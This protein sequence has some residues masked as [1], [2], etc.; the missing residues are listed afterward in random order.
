MNQATA[1]P[2]P[3]IGKATSSLTEKRILWAMLLIA[4]VLRLAYGLS[5]PP[6]VPTGGD[7]QFYLRHGYALVS[8]QPVEGVALHLLAQPPV[9]FLVNGLPQVIFAPAAAIVAVRVLQAVM[10][11][12]TAYFA[13]RMARR[14]A[15]K[16]A[17]WIAVAFVAINPI[18]ILENG[19]I[20]T[21]S[22]YV[23]LLSAAFAMY[24]DNLTPPLEKRWRWVLAGALLGLATLTRA[25]LLAFPLGLAIHLLIVY[26][27]RAWSKIAT[28]LIVYALVVSTWTVYNLVRWQRFVI[29]GEGLP[30][31][32]YV[33]AAGWA[34]PEVVDQGLNAVL[35]EEAPDDSG[36]RQG[37]YLE[38]AG[39]QIGADVPGYLRR[40]VGELVGAYLQPHGTTLFS[41]ESLRDL[42]VNWL[43]DDRS[44][45]G[46]GRVIGGEQFFPKLLLYVFHYLA[47]IFGV[48][49]AWR[50]RR[51]WRP[52]LPLLGFIAYVTLVHFFLLALPR[53]IFPT[54]LCWIVLASSQF[55]VDSKQLVQRP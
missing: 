1:Q 47:L 6:S 27:G 51:Q 45:A 39:M 32:L 48:I 28:L 33:G 37:A 16:R 10:G 2:I 21:E 35:G 49:G 41:G 34:D 40:R 18:F 29:A 55:K 22:T 23:F 36:E 14:I 17:G 43:R 19:Q 38:A 8:G 30:S 54:M 12:L 15:G 20:L 46:I 13:Y 11:T 50:S 3:T 4:L 52:T 44:L 7:Q 5:L 9:Y 42:A 26:R 53:Y 24:L 25:V 31:F